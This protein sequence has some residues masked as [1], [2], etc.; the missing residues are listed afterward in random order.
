MTAGSVAA[1]GTVLAWSQVHTVAGL[2]LVFAGL[3]LVS[4]AVL[5]EPAFAVVVR[6]FHAQRAQALLG[7]T[8]VAGFASTI[9]LPT[10]QALEQAVGWRDALVILAV[11]LAAGTVVPHALVLRRDPADLGLEPDGTVGSARGADPAPGPAEKRPTLRETARWA[12]AET[13]FRLLTLA[14]GAHTLA[15][16]V[17]SV[18]LVPYLREQG[19]SAVFAA[20]AAGALG[21]LSVTGRVAVTGAVRRWHTATVTAA[22]FAVQAVAIGVLLVLGEDVVG[23]LVFVALFGLGFGVGTITRPALLAE[24]YG[25]HDYATLSALLG[26]ALTAAK[27]AG[28]VAAGLVRTSSGSYTLVLVAVAGLS[29]LAAGAVHASRPGSRAAAGDQ[30]L[31]RSSGNA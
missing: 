9:F 16:I 24:A 25:T 30:G 19:H 29:L 5:Y 23:A 28:P 26:V 20:T 15:I 8:L 2:Y 1:V 21:I 22:A 11:V 12:F 17:V 7:I 10:T 6:W 27:T 13:R 4:A 3:G 18:H 31:A 14:Y